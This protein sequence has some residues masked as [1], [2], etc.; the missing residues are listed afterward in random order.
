MFS[1]QGEGKNKQM[2]VV[3]KYEILMLTIIIIIIIICFWNEIKKL[4]TNS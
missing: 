1:K 2:F 4:P 3:N